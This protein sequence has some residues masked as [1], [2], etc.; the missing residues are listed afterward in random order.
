MK[1]DLTWCMQLS[2]LKGAPLP[3]EFEYVATNVA[4]SLCKQ[5]QQLGKARP[6]RLLDAAEVLGLQILRSVGIGRLAHSSKVA[7]TRPIC[8]RKTACMLDSHTWL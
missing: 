2:K 1:S 5:A 8:R 7:A 3:F 4:N 6:H